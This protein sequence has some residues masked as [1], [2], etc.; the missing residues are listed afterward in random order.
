M[1]WPCARC[2]GHD[3]Y[4]SIYTRQNNHRKTI[5]DTT[6]TTTTTDRRQSTTATTTNA[7][8]T[9]TG[10]T[11]N[12]TQQRTDEVNGS[13]LKLGLNS[14]RRS[15]VSAT[16]ACAQTERVSVRALSRRRRSPL[17]VYA[18]CVC[19]GLVLVHVLRAACCSLC[20]PHTE[21]LRHHTF[22]EYTR[23]R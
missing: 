12:A 7:S 17:C 6:A 5:K 23:E 8:E 16:C 15:P 22:G 11:K 1:L 18:V 20:T 2:C 14:L 9:A 3:I 10:R 19:L 13:A 4:I 21:Q